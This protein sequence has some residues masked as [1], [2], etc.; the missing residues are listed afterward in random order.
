[1]RTL[2]VIA[3]ASVIVGA[4]SWGLVGVAKFNL[5]TALFGNTIVSSIVFALVGLAAVYQL[6]QIKAMQRRW[7]PVHA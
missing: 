2:D 7:H 4:L 5:V 3:A 6:A 1:M